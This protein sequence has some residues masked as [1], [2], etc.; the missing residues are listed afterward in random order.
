VHVSPSINFQPLF[1]DLVDV[2]NTN[3]KLHLL[4]RGEVELT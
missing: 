1:H 4:S 3:C 2:V